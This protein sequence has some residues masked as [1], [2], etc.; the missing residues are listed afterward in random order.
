MREVNIQKL[1][2]FELATH[3]S[4]NLPI[5]IVIVFQQRDRQDSQNLNNY[6]F[7]RLPDNSAQCMFGTEKILMLVYC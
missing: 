2:N 3:E 5:W 6:I 7:C 4:M 1:W